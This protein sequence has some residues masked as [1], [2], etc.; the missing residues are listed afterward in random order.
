MKPEIIEQTGKE[1]LSRIYLATLQVLADQLENTTPSDVSAATIQAA[2]KL[3]DQN[4]INLVALA[5]QSSPLIEQEPSS[6]RLAGM[7]DFD[8]VDMSAYDAPAVPSKSPNFAPFTEPSFAADGSLIHPYHA[9]QA[10][11]DRDPAA[12]IEWS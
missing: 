4:S 9:R 2:L 1:L 8:A 10:R 3:L 7:P 6:A 12:D 11:L 5:D